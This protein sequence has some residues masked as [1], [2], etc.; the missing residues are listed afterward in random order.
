MRS[1]NRNH[2]GPRRRIR[3]QERARSAAAITAATAA[4]VLG[5]AI[6]AATITRA[7]TTTPA[8]TKAEAPGYCA[9]AGSEEDTATGETTD[10][11]RCR[12]AT[13]E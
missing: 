9:Y 3:A 4:A 10:I 7:A 12:R 6:G 11:Y 1:A 2:Q 8:T 5:L 13:A